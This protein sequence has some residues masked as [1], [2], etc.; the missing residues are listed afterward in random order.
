MPGQVLMDL[1]VDEELREAIAVWQKTRSMEGKRRQ[2]QYVGRLMRAT[3]TRE[4]FRVWQ[5]YKA[6]GAADVKA[7]H[8]LEDLRQRLLDN[9]SGVWSEVFAK[10]PDIN[11]Q[12]LEDLVRE[13]RIEQK[14]GKPPRAFRAIFRLLREADGQR[15]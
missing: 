14:S 3:D 4:L 7:L 13:A 8:E 5:A 9:A 1:G 12:E 2:K 15:A 11:K 6:D 10:F